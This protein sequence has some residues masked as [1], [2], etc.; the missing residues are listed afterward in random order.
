[1]SNVSPP[2]NLTPRMKLLL[3]P[4]VGALVAGCATTPKPAKFYEG[5]ALPAEQIARVRMPNVKIWVVAVDG[6]STRDWQ[7]GLLDKSELQLAAG[8]HELTL[9]HTRNESWLQHQRAETKL[10]ASFQAD[11]FYTV[12]YR[13][14]EEKRVEFYLVDHGATYDAK[15]ARLL[16]EMSMSIY[17]GFGV[18]QECY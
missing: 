11:H 5:S 8:P 2:L 15:C 17:M 9:L 10:T 13:D 3:L 6:K 18:P 16:S 7:G 14:I 1:M 12:R 4:L